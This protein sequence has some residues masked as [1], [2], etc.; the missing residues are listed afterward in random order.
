MSVEIKL[1][2]IIDK[3]FAS[4]KKI[5]PALVALVVFTGCILFL[6]ENVLKTIG[7]N[8]LPNAWRT[9]IGIVFLLTSSIV[10]VILLSYPTNA[11]WR[12][13]QNNRR[14]KL[15]KKRYIGLSKEHKAIICTMFASKEKGGYLCQ[16]DGTTAYLLENLFI[17]RSTQFISPEIIMSERQY[18]LYCL[19]PW[20]IDLLNKDNELLDVSL[21]DTELIEK[22]GIFDN[23]Y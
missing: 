10:L 1:N 17:L 3:I 20:V 6:P 11:I 22:H 18:F 14:Y 21:V 4:F 9:A 15:L 2:D 8:D 5:T 23:D 13:I 12:K 7:L 19:Q 16:S